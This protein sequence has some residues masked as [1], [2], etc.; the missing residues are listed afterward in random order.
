MFVY[1]YE[2]NDIE[3]NIR[4]LDKVRARYGASNDGAIDRYLVEQYADGSLLRC[5]GQ[6]ADMTFK[7]AEFLSQYYIT[8]YSLTHCGTWISTR[9]HLR[10][11]EAEVEAPALEGPAP[12]LAEENIMAAMNVF[13]R[14]LK[15]LRQRF[16][17]MPITVVYVPSPL[18]V[19]HHATDTV[20]FCS[21]TGG[22]P[23]G[24]DVAAQHHQMMRD[25]AA[26]MSAA[27]HIDFV[28]ATPALRAAGERHVIHGPEDWDHL[29]KGGYEVLGKLVAARVQSEPEELRLQ[30]V[31]AVRK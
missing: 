21:P 30:T 24:A 9:N 22:G 15:W 19:Y 6:L 17:A 18:S 13:A 8:G 26:R 10:V 12:H 2:G 27:A 31:G 4:F 28:D 14:S 23:I 20:A 16:P 29:N 3:D 5:H 1:F 7:L 25:T 11:G